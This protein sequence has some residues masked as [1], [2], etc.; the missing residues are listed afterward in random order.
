MSVKNVGDE[1]L[2]KE[3]GAVKSPEVKSGLMAFTTSLG[4]SSCPSLP[5]ITCRS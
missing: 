4:T 2:R 3:R 1:S 5:N